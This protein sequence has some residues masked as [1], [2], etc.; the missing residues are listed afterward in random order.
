MKPLKLKFYS[1]AGHGWLAVKR[2]LLI[3]LGLINKI[4][5]FSYERGK[6][7]YLEE[8]CDAA[9]FVE[10]AKAAGYELNMVSGAWAERSPIR[11]YNSFNRDVYSF[12]N[13]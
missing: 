10:T 2:D 3:K 8:D 4:S 5:H 6:T 11:S 12:H 9:L 7:I 1:D 13:N